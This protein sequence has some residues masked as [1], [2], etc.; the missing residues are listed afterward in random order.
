[1]IISLDAGK[2]FIDNP[3]PLHDK[4]PVELRHT[5]DI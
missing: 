4:S 3:S 2:A 1:M 5:S